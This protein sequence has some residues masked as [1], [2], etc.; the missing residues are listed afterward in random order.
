M[1][2]ADSP[3]GAGG[4]SWPVRVYYED[5]DLGGVVYYA[6]YLRYLERARTEWLRA[7]G[8]EQSAL[9]A[10]HHRYDDDLGGPQGI[11]PLDGHQLGIARTH[12]DSDQPAAHDVRHLSTNRRA[13]PGSDA[14]CVCR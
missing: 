10:V 14:Q 2:R 1:T 11:D 7:R 9:A 3:P 5:T 12:A 13:A 6:N 4:F 8:V